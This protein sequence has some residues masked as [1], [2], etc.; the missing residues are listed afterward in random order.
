MIHIETPV[1]H[2]NGQTKSFQDRRAA[3]TFINQAIRPAL[4]GF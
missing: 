4:L 2:L 1:I 3:E